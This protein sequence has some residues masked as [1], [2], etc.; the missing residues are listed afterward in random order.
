MFNFD[1][2]SNNCIAK[3]ASLKPVTGVKSKITNCGLWI[4][5]ENLINV[6]W[7]KDCKE[8]CSVD[9]SLHFKDAIEHNIDTKKLD[10]NNQEII[11]EGYCITNPR[12]LIVG[13][14]NLLKTDSATRKTLGYWKKGDNAFFDTITKKKQFTCVRR[15]R[16][17]FVDSENNFLHSKEQS[18]QLSASG[19]FQMHFDKMFM[20]FKVKLAE[21]Y[22]KAQ[23]KN[24]ALKT[25]TWYAFTIFCPQFETKMVGPSKDKESKACITSS[26]TIPTIENW[27]DFCVAYDPEKNAVVTNI[28]DSIKGWEE[29][30]FRGTTKKESSEDEEATLEE[31]VAF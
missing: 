24:V 11:I 31:E 12:M 16:I 2:E 14:S 6:S 22:C 10:N 27:K 5:K 23:G 29:K 20:A 1:D 4:A 26:Y 17:M 13:R 25:D 7:A 21:V 8:D 19:Y 28:I 15:Y 30:S 3:V 18:I 9:C